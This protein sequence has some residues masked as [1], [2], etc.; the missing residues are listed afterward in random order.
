[1]KLPGFTKMTLLKIL[2]SREEQ[3]IFFPLNFNQAPQTG[4]SYLCCL[5][6]AVVDC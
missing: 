5:T 4:R 2:I 6:S 1:M 3:V